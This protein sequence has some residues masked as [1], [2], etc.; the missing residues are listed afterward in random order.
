MNAAVVDKAIL[1]NP[2]KAIRLSAIL[3][4]FSRAPKWVP[5]AD[6]VVALLAVVTPEYQAAIWLGAGQ[7]MR[8]GEVLAMEDGNRC[9]DYFHRE[10]H[11]VQQ[12]R[13]HKAAYGGFYLA[14]PK[15]GSVGD[16]DLD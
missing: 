10:V 4:G 1:D 11:V 14:P 5:T 7:G 3:R 15:S 9:V 13:F 16:V 8:L 6:D 2:C 12:L